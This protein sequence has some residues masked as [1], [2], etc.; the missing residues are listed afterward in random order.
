M[1]IKAFEQ[2]VKKHPGSMLTIAGSGPEESKLHALINRYQLGEKVQIIGAIPHDEL[3]ARMAS[4]D[5]IL[6][7]SLRDGEEQWLL[8]RCR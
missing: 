8:K 4:S 5:V 7:P 1:A 6:F 3:L 2:F